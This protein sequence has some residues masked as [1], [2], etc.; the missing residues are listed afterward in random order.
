MKTKRYKKSQFKL[1]QN[2]LTNDAIYNSKTDTYNTKIKINQN[3]YVLRIQFADND[4][5]LVWEAVEINKN[6]ENGGQYTVIANNAL[7]LSM[8]NILVW[9]K[10][11]IL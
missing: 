10:A 7:L 5:I 4:R 6:T 1:I 2:A 8:L 3:E 11:P 9:Q